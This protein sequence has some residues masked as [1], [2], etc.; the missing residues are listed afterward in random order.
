MQRSIV[1]LCIIA[2]IANFVYAQSP[3]P[4]V[5]T[6]EFEVTGL[7]YHDENTGKLISHAFLSVPYAKP[8]VG[9]L[10]LE[11]PRALSPNSTWRFNGHELPPG[12]TQQ[13][14]FSRYNFT[15]SEDCL[16]L[17]VMAPPRPSPDGKGYPVLIWIHGGGFVYG[18]DRF[19]GWQQLAKHFNPR[20]IVVVAIQYRV[21]F[22]GFF[23][24]GDQNLPGNLGLWDQTAALH[25]VNSRINLFGGDPS[26]ITVWGNSAG[27]ASVHS[28]S[29]SP[30]SN[31]Y[32]Q[33]S[34]Q[35]SG[36]LYNFWSNTRRTYQMS[37]EIADKVGCSSTD[38]AKVKKCLK[39]VPISTV[40]QATKQYGLMRT[41][42]MHLVY[43]GPILADEDFFVGKHIPMLTQAAPKKP[44]LYG[45]T[46]GEGLLFTLMTPNP[47][48]SVFAYGI[49]VNV[50]DQPKFT[51][52]NLTNFIHLYVANKEMAG[53][54]IGKVRQILEDHYLKEDQ[55]DGDRSRFW[56]K[57]FT[58]LMSDGQFFAGVLREIGEKLALS[59][60]EQY[61]Y[62]LDYVHPSHRALIGVDGDYTPHA[63]EYQYLTDAVPYFPVSKSEFN[64]VEHRFTTRLVDAF[65][66]FV[67][68]GQPG[69]EEHPWPPVQD[70]IQPSYL[71]L[72]E[73]IQIENTFFPPISKV[74][75]AVFATGYGSER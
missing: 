62:F 48:T 74:W 4:V 6:P 69:T 51:K 30:H 42:S 3:N 18:M 64:D 75:Q 22:W 41:D 7:A 33:R 60:K 9:N 27:A 28:L 66:E 70:E 10:R 54:N 38:T 45:L 8:P 21:A 25:F 19:Y 15:T 43:W 24:L 57:R 50:E 58:D 5:K 56:F 67:N 49:G 13:E 20:N 23:A 16:Y 65:A 44:T 61:L 52:E 35:S 40:W 34:I 31:Q 55:S 37:R 2:V 14:D 63:Y 12:C 17:N 47:V 59:W 39:K 29:L 32:F 71:R 72:G 1:T 36:S 46:K 11:L 53:D 68:G 26:R 73:V